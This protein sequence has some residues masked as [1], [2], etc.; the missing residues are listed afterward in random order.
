MTPD[1]VPAQSGGELKSRMMEA[2][3]AGEPF[4]VYRDGDGAQ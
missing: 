2:E 1:A 4:L 3:R